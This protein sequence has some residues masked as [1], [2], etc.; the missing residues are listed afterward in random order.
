M[1]F[2]YTLELRHYV[3]GPNCECYDIGIFRTREDAE[4][5]AQRYLQEVPGFCD[6]ECDYFIEQIELECSDSITHLYAYVGSN[7]NGDGA[8]EDIISELFPEKAQ[9]EAAMEAARAAQTRENWKVDC[10]EIGACEWAEGFEW[11]FPAGFSAFTLS[12]LREKLR[13]STEPYTVY[14]YDFLYSENPIFGHT[15]T[16][17]DKLFLMRYENKVQGHSHSIRQIRDLYNLGSYDLVL[18]GVEVAMDVDLTDWRS[19]FESLKDRNT[20]VTVRQDYAEP[21]S[22]T[23]YIAAIEHEQVLIY[24]VLTDEPSSKSNPVAIKIKFI[25]AIDFYCES[26]CEDK[27]ICHPM[28]H[29]F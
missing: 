2:F 13:A 24:P 29:R 5:T 12:E 8:A 19:A 9:A 22:C 27:V 16:L 17:G 25:T 4:R 14:H 11:V 10:W 20:L 26:T 21:S 18:K 3:Y 6:Y 15:V 23:G 1:A 7:T 28:S